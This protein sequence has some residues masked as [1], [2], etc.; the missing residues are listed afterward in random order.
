MAKYFL[1]NLALED[2]TNIWNYTFDEWS[3]KQ[4][5]KYYDSLLFAC[6]EVAENPQFG[7]TYDNVISNLQGFRNGKHVIFYREMKPGIIEVA[8]ILHERMDFKRK[9]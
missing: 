6:Q 2:L 9:L 3:E 1:T 5:D 8:R 4:A 7:K